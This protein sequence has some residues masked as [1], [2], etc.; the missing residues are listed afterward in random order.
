[1]LRRGHNAQEEVAGKAEEGQGADEGIREHSQAAGSLQR[2]ASH[3]R[4]SGRLPIP[5]VR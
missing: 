3:W 1:M 5:P 2:R 4:R